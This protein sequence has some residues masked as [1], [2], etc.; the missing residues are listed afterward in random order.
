MV[1]D[2]VPSGHVL[3][4]AE[5]APDCT[6]VSRLNV[7]VSTYATE[8]IHIAV[9]TAVIMILVL[10]STC[11]PTPYVKALATALIIPV[12][13]WWSTRCLISDIIMISI[14]RRMYLRHNLM[15]VKMVRK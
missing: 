10:L 11:P 4:I 13:S 12:L 9:T 1:L 6:T 5:H 8:L 14:R 7:V 3:V 15:V 2:N